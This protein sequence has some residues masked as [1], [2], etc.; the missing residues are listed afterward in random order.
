MS[1]PFIILLVG[2]LFTFFFGGLTFIRREGLSIRFAIESI[3]ITLLF[4]GLGFLFKLNIEPIL[5]LLII[6]VVT[7]RV[8]ILVDLG[9][10]MAKRKNF[11]L[12]DKIY[13]FSA[14]LWPDKSNALIIDVNRG[15]SVLQYGNL[16]EA[17]TIFKTVLARTEQGFLGIKYET[18]TH[19]NLGV[20]YQRKNLPSLALQEF[21]A[22]IEIWPGSI[23]SR[24]AEA[25]IKKIQTKNVD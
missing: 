7:M 11:A 2:F 12:A 10:L 15:T 5:F 25:A 24:V 13:Q 21:E 17:I 20:A 9:N 6:Y 4:S 19:Y 3:I 14:R 23:Y 8:R 18:A 1:A 22:V 16:D